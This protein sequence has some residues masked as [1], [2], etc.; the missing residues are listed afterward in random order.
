MSAVHSKAW[1]TEPA[2]RAPPDQKPRLK[3][4]TL[5]VVAPGVVLATLLTAWNYSSK[6]LWRDEWY[7]LSTANRPL[8]DM[9]EII[10]GPDVGLA[11]FYS[12]MHLWLLV[13]DAVWWL[14]LPSAL[15]T[16]ALSVVTA[17]LARRLAGLAAG[18]S[19]GLLIAVLPPVVLHAQEARAYPLVLLTTTA[20][21]L[22]MLR[23]RDHP[24]PR[25]A[26]G[27]VVVAALPGCLHPIVGLPAVAGLFL[28]AVISPGRAARSRLVLISL[29]AAAGGLL[30]IAAGFRQQVG[31]AT[32]ER[33][34]V[35]DLAALP[36]SLVGPL[37]ITALLWGLVV[38]GLVS[39]GSPRPPRH[40]A[41]TWVVLTCW[42]LAPFVVVSGMGLGG[43]FFRAR[44][45]SDATPVLAVLA[46]MGLGCLVGIVVSR[47]H[48]ATTLVVG[49]AT[50]VALVPLVP[51]AGLLRDRT[52]YADDPRS[53]ALAIAADTQPGDAVVYIGPTARGMT[54]YY[55]P[56]STML[57]DV[58]MTQ[59]PA[60]SKSITGRE[61][62]EEDRDE[63]L[64]GHP[65]VWVV[66]LTSGGTW[67]DEA[68]AADATANRSRISDDEYG[69][70][71]VELWEDSLKSTR[72]GDR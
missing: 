14:R 26:W 58:L 52:Y 51:A 1:R 43:S 12:V 42:L 39:L 48:L 34:S 44:Y 49:G 53:A 19:A 18:V 2:H 33:P 15:A 63:A 68:K 69:N 45:V 22:L 13:D 50:I 62:P 31:A 66:A 72:R 17:L 40:G 38:V 36:G 6:P 65:R 61:V 9:L 55:L 54:T 21:A 64:S 70:V 27:L 25:L 47:R 67:P 3:Y 23:Y 32:Q 8:L 7:T 41:G 46:A 4:E 60:Q 59:S 24:T 35:G 71:R 37:W 56:D 11:G 20:T 28:G 29:P 16:V 10:K 30:L 5:L 57:D